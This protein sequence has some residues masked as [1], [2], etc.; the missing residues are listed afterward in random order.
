MKIHPSSILH[1]S[2]PPYLLFSEVVQTGKCYIRTVTK[3]K[4]EWLE[5]VV[6]EYAKQQKFVHWT[7]SNGF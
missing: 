1:L 5:E 6:P 2:Y 4:P 7:P 3:I